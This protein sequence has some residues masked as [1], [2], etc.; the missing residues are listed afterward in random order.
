MRIIMTRKYVGNKY[1]NTAGKFAAGN[2]GKPKGA[3]QDVIS[4]ELD[5]RAELSKWIEGTSS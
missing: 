4:S 5:A 1:T 2:P 3:R